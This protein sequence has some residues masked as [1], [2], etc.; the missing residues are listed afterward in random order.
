MWVTKPHQTLSWLQKSGSF[1]LNTWP[2]YHDQEKCLTSL[3][4]VYHVCV[5]LRGSGLVLGALEPKLPISRP[6]PTSGCRSATFPGNGLES[7]GWWA[8]AEGQGDTGCLA[9]CLWLALA[10]VSVADGQ[11]P[12]LTTGGF[13]VGPPD[14]S[15]FLC[16]FRHP[17]ALLCI[18]SVPF[19]DT[20][21]AGTH[22]REWLES[23][24]AK[25]TEEKVLPPGKQRQPWSVTTNLYKT[26]GLILYFSQQVPFVKLEA[27]PSILIARHLN[28]LPSISEWH[29]CGISALINYGV[30]ALRER[31]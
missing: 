5:L 15:L 31:L 17:S 29:P 30:S 1:L 12:H 7:G 3:F 24:P 21:T 2:Q 14:H 9:P 25:S 18:A 20:D 4:K 23:P 11:K 28:G 19:P 6:S 16:N 8:H 13:L 27:L 22:T 10:Q 26:Q